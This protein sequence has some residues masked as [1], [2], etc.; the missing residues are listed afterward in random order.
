[1]RDSQ[2]NHW[3]QKTSQN[4]I[5]KELKFQIQEISPNKLNHMN[6]IY[7]VAQCFS[8]TTQFKNSEKSK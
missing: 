3:I 4:I 7:L 5:A 6:K 1:M 8:Q 2:S